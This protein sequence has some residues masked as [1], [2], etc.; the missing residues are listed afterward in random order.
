MEILVKPLLAL[1]LCLFLPV[2]TQASGLTEKLATGD[3]PEADK[4][5][6]AGRKPGEVVAFL[7]IDPGMTVVDLIAASGYYTEVLSVAVGPNGKV[8][9]QN[10][11]FSLTFREGRNDKAMTARLANNRLPNVER[12]DREIRD[13]GLAPDSVDA[14]LTA[15]NFHDI[16]NGGSPEAAAGFLAAVRTFLK[17]GG[18][19][20]L[21]DHDGDSGQDNKKLHRIPEATVRKAVEASGFVIAAQADMLQNPDDDHS[22]NVFDPAIRGNTDRF[23]LLLR[24]P[25]E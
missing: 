20:G 11:E 6:D 22:R 13:L 25:S 4:A 21:I 10:S 19:L 9:A 12:L 23:V 5:R 15:L 17:P 24:K 3:R 18:T 14:A 16:F 2:G 1:F 8:Y 7:E